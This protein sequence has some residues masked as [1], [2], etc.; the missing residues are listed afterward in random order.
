MPVPLPYPN[1]QRRDYV[2]RA[3][4]DLRRRDPDRPLRQILAMVLA[5]WR[6]EKAQ[7]R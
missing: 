6:R 5:T 4:A 1:E 3:V 2:R 7:G